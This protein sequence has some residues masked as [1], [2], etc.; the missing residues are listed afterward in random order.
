MSPEK[1][2]ELL[3][4]WIAGAA[5][6]LVSKVSVCGF[7]LNLQRAARQVFVGL[8]DSYEQY[9]QAIRRSWRF[10]QQRPVNVHV[11]AAEP[12]R[13][14]FDNVLRKEREAQ[15]MATELVRCV[16]AYEREA[17][18]ISGRVDANYLPKVEIRLPE[19]LA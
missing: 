7:G 11:V 12:E 8:N 15:E 2:V 18:G 3:E 5:P 10:G 6:V 9:Y 17:L 19:W 13:A 16:A 14:V 4:A 1:K